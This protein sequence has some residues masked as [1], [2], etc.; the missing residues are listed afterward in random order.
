MC[1]FA[2]EEATGQSFQEPLYKGLRW[3]YGENELSVDMRDT[4]NSLIWRCILPAN[5]KTKFW[6]I[7]MSAIRLANRDSNKRALEVLYEQRP[8][9]YGW[10]LYA[11]ARHA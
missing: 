3:I 10:L 2:V 7:A 9:E 6:D 11:F 5:R 8:Y 4:S 1:L